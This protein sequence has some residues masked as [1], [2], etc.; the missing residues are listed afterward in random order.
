M[1]TVTAGDLEV[2]VSWGDGNMTAATTDTPNAGY[3]Q[4]WKQTNT[5]GTDGA[6]MI[7]KLVSAGGSVTVGG[8]WSAAPSAMV[9]VSAAYL[10]AGSTVSLP[11][12]IMAPAHR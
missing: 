12:L 4:S 9:S 7:F 2:G 1:S 6:T 8:T 5:T 11:D 10:A 3:T